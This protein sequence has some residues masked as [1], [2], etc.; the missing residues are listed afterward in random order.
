MKTNNV[1]KNKT[2]SIIFL[3]PINIHI[4]ERHPAT[5]KI[6]IPK[7][8]IIVIIIIFLKQTINQKCT[9]QT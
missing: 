9:R 3:N 5:I 1:Y 8:V 6:H 4:R 7:A 2:K